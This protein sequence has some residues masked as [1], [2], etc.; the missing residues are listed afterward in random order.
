V[1]PRPWS[2]VK[3]I[4]MSD[5]Q[6]TPSTADFI[7]TGVVCAVV[8]F[9]VLILV[10]HLFGDAWRVAAIKSAILAVVISTAVTV[11]NVRKRRSG[12]TRS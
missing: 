5:T 7:E 8:V 3:E 6:K 1:L 9:L 10:E 4:I 2:T 11:V 12:P